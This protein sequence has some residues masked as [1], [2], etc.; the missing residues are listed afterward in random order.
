MRPAV[1]L[2]LLAAAPAYPQ[3]R[4]DAPLRKTDLVRLLSGGTLGRDDLAALIQRSC[5]SF[6]PTS[7]DRADLLALGADPLVLREI[8]RCVRRV[9]TA[10]V[11]E[12][13]PSPSLP[14]LSGAASGFVLGV[15][16]HAPAG[17]HPPVPLLFELRDTAG[18]PAAGREVALSITNGWL[19]ADRVVTDSNGRVHVDL[20]VGPRVGPV[21]VKA[22]VGA[23]ERQATLYA[24]PG[25]AAKVTLRCDEAR[26]ERRLALAPGGVAALRVTA[27]DAFGNDAS[28][29]GLQAATGDRGVLRVTSVGVEAGGGVVRLTAGDEGSTSLVVVAS[30]LR[31]DVS[32]TVAAVALPGVTR[33]P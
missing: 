17:S 5:L 1:A 11:S 15:G 6:T 26:V 8:D 10:G 23:I 18:S 20:A 31:E 12:V 28:V 13:T 3:V 29:T 30:H 21:E 2:L 24:E 9:V 16:Q 27:E 33:C 7:K 25:P 22:R 32:V 14:P 4:A 19:G